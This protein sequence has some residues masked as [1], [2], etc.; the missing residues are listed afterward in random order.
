MGRMLHP[1]CSG[2]QRNHTR[3]CTLVSP[4]S[5]TVRTRS[6]IAIGSDTHAGVVQAW[7]AQ[8]VTFLRCGS[9]MGIGDSPCTLLVFPWLGEVVGA[10][11]AMG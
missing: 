10:S 8:N 6:M 11:L 9:D 3:M 4:P 2:S 1:V 7:V 5:Q